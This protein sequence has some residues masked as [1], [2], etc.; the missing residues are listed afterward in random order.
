M[1]T[2][3][4][5]EEG[6]E[7]SARVKRA[8]GAIAAGRMVVI[9]DAPEREDEADL[10]MAAD[11]TSSDD[12]A[13]MVRHAS[14]IVCVALAGD[15]VAELQ[16]PPMAAENTDLN[17]TAFTVSVD[18]RSGT[19]TGVSAADRARTINALADRSCTAQDFRRPGHVFPLR[20]R[21]GGVL[22]RAGHTEA[23]LDLARLAGRSPAGV[24]CELMND[25]GTMMRGAALR[26]FAAERDLPLLSI[27]ELILYRTTTETL[28]QLVAT[29]KMPTRFGEFTAHV[30]Q[31]TLDDAEHL[32]LTMGSVAGSEP[33]LVRVHSE[34]LTGDSFGSLRC[35]CGEQLA[36]ALRQISRARCGVLVY[37]RGQEGRGIG[38]GHKLR[39]YAL[40]DRGSDTVEANLELGLP[41]DSREYGIGA[42]ILA[43]LG[44]QKLRVLTNNP[45]KY[46]GLA[47][48]GLEVVD[49]VPLLTSPRQQ[50]IAYLR[51]KEERLGHLLALG[52]RTI[53]NPVG[54]L[55][56]ALEEVSWP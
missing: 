18:Y 55:S 15:R 20:A 54:G 6:P 8:I 49:R 13:L 29:T 2:N 12:A 24:L 52:E 33:V 9:T 4:F 37:L 17:G 23:A 5:A 25:D 46:S 11:T 47:G 1:A 48:Y 22:K 14:G 3:A 31:S 50:N 28:V 45:A 19:T 56:S 26:T 32:A 7:T 51:T 21:E 43:Q 38:L 30:F 41:V 36:M 35:D 27:D 39:A 53:D 10:I 34:C 44:V 42:Q 16:L 40:Q